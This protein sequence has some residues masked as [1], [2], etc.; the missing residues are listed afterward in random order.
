[1]KFYEV[2]R[3]INAPAEQI[4]AVLTDSGALTGGKFGI[5]KIE[6]DIRAGGKLKLWSEADP[7]RAFALKVALFDAPREMQW[8]GGMPLGLFRGVRRFTL[9]PNQTGCEFH[10]REE[11]SG[12]MSGLITRSMPDLQ[13]LFDRFGDALK[14]VAEG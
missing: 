13:P 14:S 10:M 9:T 12:L 6:G 7:K 8:H 3:Q 11:F 5:L 1:M 2:I 4:W